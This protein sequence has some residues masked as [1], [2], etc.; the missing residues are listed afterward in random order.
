MLAFGTLAAWQATGRARA[1][2]Q[3]VSHSQPLSQNAAE[4]YRSLA[5]ADATAASAFLL[6]GDAPQAVRDRY[7]ADLDTAARLL[8]EAAARTGS[9]SDAQQWV[10]TLN[11]QLPQYAGL[12]E[13]A[14]ADNRQ[15][16]PLGGAYLRYASKQM[17]ES[18]LPAAERLAAVEAAQLDGDYADAGAFPWAAL[19]LGGLT[20]AALIRCQVLLLRRTNRVFSPGLLGAT[21]AVLAAVLWLATGSLSARSDL[22]DSREHGAVPLRTL[23]QARIEALQSHTAENMDLVARGASDTYAARWAALTGALAGPLAGDG[24]SR[25]GGGNLALARAGAPGEA[26]AALARA[27]DLFTTWDGRHQAAAKSNEQGDYD[28]ALRTTVGASDDS[29]EGVFTALDQQLARAATAEQTAFT[30]SAKGTDG[31]LD[32]VAAGAAVLAVL[33]AVGVIR[34]LGRRLA[35]YR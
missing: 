20:L 26:D 35:E 18:M 13:T 33:A 17:Q 5:D 7:R 19:V 4:I 16:L 25:T 24:G 2:D 15:G 8:A 10:A 21:A 11:R 28:A 27:L 23:D 12:V 9:S 31:V 22:T 6:A 3:V 32:A 34:G 1:A 14:G 30:R 29:A